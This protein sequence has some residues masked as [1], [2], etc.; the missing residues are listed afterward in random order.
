MSEGNFLYNPKTRNL[1]LGLTESRDALSD[2]CLLQ[3]AGRYILGGINCDRG[4]AS[5]YF[6]LDTGAGTRTDFRTH[7]ALRSAARQMNID[8]HLDPFDVVF[9]RYRFTWFDAAAAAGMF[10]IPL[11][12]AWLIYRWV[13]RLRKSGSVN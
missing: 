12:C 10:G 1:N 8:V 13:V 6:L 11:V 5:S 3:L 9:Y 7:H 4:A 2:V